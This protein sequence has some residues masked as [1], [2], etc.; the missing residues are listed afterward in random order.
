[1]KS[2]DELLRELLS[3]LDAL[4]Y[5]KPEQIPDIPLYMDQLTTFMDEQLE[6]SKRYPEDKVLTKTMINNY[7]KNNLLP[8]PVK[9]K[10]TKEHTL[11]LIFIYYF[12][13]MLSFHDIEILFG[14]ITEAH[15]HTSETKKRAGD[16]QVGPSQSEDKAG[17]SLEDIYRQIFSLEKEQMKRLKVDIIKKFRSSMNTFPVESLSSCGSPD[18]EESS[19]LQKDQEY[20]QLFSFICALGFDVYL[21]KQIM[22]LLIDQIGEELPPNTK[23]KK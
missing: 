19:S 7:A 13:N 3:R 9:K 16:G 15:F 21:K 5:V 18:G 11:L 2:N 17:W 10:Y 8:P 22:E 23:K 14:P 6:K 1:M 12:K 4:D 20:L